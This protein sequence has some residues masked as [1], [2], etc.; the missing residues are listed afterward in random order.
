MSV[1]VGSL[2]FLCPVDFILETQEYSINISSVQDYLTLSVNHHVVDE[3]EVLVKKHNKAVKA[4]C[5]DKICYCINIVTII[6]ISYLDSK[7][8]GLPYMK[9]RKGRKGGGGPNPVSCTNFKITYDGSCV[10]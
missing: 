8:E 1:F 4:Y 7:L 9:G 2:V 10:L 6:L 3:W 5:R